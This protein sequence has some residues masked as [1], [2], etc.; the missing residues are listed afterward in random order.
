MTKKMK[1]IREMKTEDLN[2]KLSELRLEL[3]K[4][5]GN[6]KMGKASKNVGKIG[7]IKKDIARILTLKSSGSKKK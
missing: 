5:T 7:Q 3:M 2:K 4:E 1:E 6:I